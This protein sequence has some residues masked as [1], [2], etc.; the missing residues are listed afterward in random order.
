MRSPVKRLRVFE[1]NIQL[2]KKDGE[3]IIKVRIVITASTRTIT[4]KT[5]ILTIMVQS[6]QTQTQT[7]RLWPLRAP[8]T[9]IG[10]YL[11]TVNPLLSAR[12]MSAFESSSIV[13]NSTAI[14]S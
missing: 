12:V 14:A 5:A 3:L 4:I 6:E 9:L 7:A 1:G 11:L 13:D 10:I 8:P 2:T